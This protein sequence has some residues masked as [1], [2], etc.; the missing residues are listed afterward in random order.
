MYTYEDGTYFTARKQTLA[1]VREMLT[2]L[3]D[4]L[5]ANVPNLAQ[6]HGT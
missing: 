1:E 5:E 6:P 2:T 3:V 4:D